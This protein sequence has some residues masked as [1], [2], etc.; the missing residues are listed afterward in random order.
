MP[1]A[2]PFAVPAKV[3][4]LQVNDSKGQR[5]TLFGGSDGLV[6]LPQ[7]RQVVPQRGY[8]PRRLVSAAT[9]AWKSREPSVGADRGRRG[10]PR[11]R[12][13]PGAR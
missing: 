1:P 8:D 7:T 12:E 2:V 10:G 13:G 4:H 3:A 11:L 6:C 9:P 5:F